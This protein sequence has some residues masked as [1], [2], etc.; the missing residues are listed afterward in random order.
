MGQVEQVT[1]SI[2]AAPVTRRRCFLCTTTARCANT[3]SIRH[4]EPRRLKQTK[5]FFQ[6]DKLYIPK[7]SSI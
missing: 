5:S 2:P 4:S 7:C 3:V 6:T 1:Y